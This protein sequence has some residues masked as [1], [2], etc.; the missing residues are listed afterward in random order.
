M[1]F[2]EDDQANAIE[3]R[4][5]LKPADE[6]AFCDD[7]Y[8]SFRAYPTF[9]SNSVT[10]R[11]TNRFSKCLR[12]TLGCGACGQSTRLKHHDRLAC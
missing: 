11:I 7:F 4:I 12:H 2:V 5:L 3:C 9:E 10:D 1:E 6:Y 8:P